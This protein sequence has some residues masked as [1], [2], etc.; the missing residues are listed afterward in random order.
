MSARKFA[1]QVLKFAENFAQYNDWGRPDEDEHCKR[2]FADLLVD[3]ED[4]LCC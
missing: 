4:Q 1:L 3:L 2:E